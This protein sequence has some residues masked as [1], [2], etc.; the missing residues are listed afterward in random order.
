MSSK[1]SPTAEARPAPAAD[2]I[3]RSARQ[4]FY[5]QGIRAVGVDAIVAEAGVTKPSLYRSFSSKDELAAAYLR[6]Y[7]AEFWARLDQAAAEHPDDPRAQILAYFQGLS[8]R[9]A[10]GGS[11]RGC[12]LSNAVVEY[13]EADH[14]ARLVA[15][16]H[17]RELR[18]RLV[19]LARDMGAR[20][21]DVLGDG[22][23]LLL[24]GAFVS[25]QIFGKGGPVVRLREVADRLIAASL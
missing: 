24:E 8:Q 18:T 23:L 20:D 2:R 11:Y 6:D 19:A 15:V 25:G 21:P 14:P 10:R 17:K 1:T 7:E 22:L 9:A 16:A 4:L 13:P 3:R 5:H 12:G